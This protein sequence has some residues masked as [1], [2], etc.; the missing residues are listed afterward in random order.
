MRICYISHSSSHF[1]RPYV[2]Y[3]SRAGHD[4]HLVSVDLPN[5]ESGV[6]FHSLCAPFDP[7]TNKLGYLRALSAISRTIR[8][9]RPDIVHAHYLTSN[10]FLAAFANVHP[11]IVSARGSD[12]YRSFHSSFRR[13]ALRFVFSRADLIN[14]VSES[15]GEKVV[16]LGAL[17]SRVSCLSQGIETKRFLVE[18]S[19]RRPGP[20]RIIHTR[21]LVDIQQGD[22]IIEALALLKRDGIPFQFTFAATGPQQGILEALAREKSL[23]SHITF[24]GG[25]H[26]KDKTLPTLL[27]WADIYVSASLWDG[28]SPSLFEAMA[29]GAFPVVSDIPGNRDW[30]SGDR[31]SLFF[32]PYDTKQL[33]DQLKRAIGDEAI[34]REAISLNHQKVT[35]H[36]ERSM[37]MATLTK[38]YEQLI[39]G[40]Q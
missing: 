3:F 15:L 21:S 20:I 23:D 7:M 8:A 27:S 34:R 22:K 33:V 12:V 4:V 38:V 31:D 13:W 29:S 24:L 32:D 36:G 37:N 26:Y 30:L 17:T 1:T 39:A 9:I 14:V 2:E 16:Q 10:G 25:Y 35:Q 28:A 5:V 11:L 6:T 40:G 18:R 19:I